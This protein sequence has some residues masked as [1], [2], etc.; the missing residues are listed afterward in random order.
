M[1]LTWITVA[2]LGL[3]GLFLA[4]QGPRLLPRWPR[5]WP[6]LWPRPASRR[7][8][9]PFLDRIINTMPDP[10][11]VKDED[12]RFLL[13][14]DAFCRLAGLPLQD[15]LGRPARE[16][17]PGR[18]GTASLKQDAMVLA[19]G[20]ED[21]VEETALDAKGERRTFMTRKSLHLDAREQRHVV[22]VIRDIS[23]RK[24]AER[25]LAASE[26]RYR[27][28]VETANEGVWAVDARWRTTYVNAVMAAMLGAEASGNGR[29]AGQGL[30][31][32]RGPGPAPGPDPLRS[33]TPPAAASTN[34]ACAARTARNSGS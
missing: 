21:I 15:I 16:V 29:P 25:A 12:G 24:Q 3:L 20:V 31:L 19:S 23:S 30:P 9:D 34:A 28:F 8:A 2:G 33:R 5:L 18:S 13:V 22:G 27:R 17:F 1:D 26:A 4:L 14:N 6:R 10:F 32:C 7:R 11:Y